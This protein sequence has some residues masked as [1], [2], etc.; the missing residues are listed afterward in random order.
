MYDWITFTTDYGLSDGFVA[1]CH[2]V[3]A[4]LA[5]RVRVLDVTHLIPPGDVRRAAAVLAQTVPYLPRAVHVAVVD[6]GVGTSRRAVALLTGDGSALVG[7]DNGVLPDAAD[8]L[9]GIERAVTL[10]NPAWHAKRVTA[11]FHGRDIFLPVAAHLAAG[12]TITDAGDPL[13]PTELIRLPRLTA[14]R[15]GDTIISPVLTVDRFG[16][17]QLAGAPVELPRELAVDGHPAVL[18]TTFADAP[19]GGLVVLVDSAGY[20]AVAAN[21]ANAADLLRKKPGDELWISPAGTPWPA[22]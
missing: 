9:G 2:G 21:G 22:G 14:R 18:G 17:L 12:A 4:R 6:P 5:P 20:L 13:D 10:T 7:P 15:E 1:A 11:T 3:A 16:N 19:P 8:A